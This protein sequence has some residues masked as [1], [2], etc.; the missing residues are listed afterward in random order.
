MHRSELIVLSPDDLAIDFIPRGPSPP[1]PQPIELGG[2]RGMLFAADRVVS[3]VREPN[4]PSPSEVFPSIG[5][6]VREDARSAVASWSD[7][8]DRSLRV[9]WRIRQVVR[10]LRE[11]AQTELELARA[12][13]DYVLEH[14]QH[15]RGGAPATFTLATGHGDAL[16]LFATLLRAAGLEPDI[17]YA[18]NLAADRS[19]PYLAPGE[20]GATLVRVELDDETWW[21]MVGSRHAPF[22]YLPATLRGQPGLLAGGTPEEVVLPAI[23]P[24]SDLVETHIEG[25]IN[26]DGTVT[27]DVIERFVGARATEFRTQVSRIPAAERELRGA[28]MLGHQFAGGVAE[29]VSFDGV[30]DRHAP[31][32]LHASI[33][34]RMLIRREEGAILVPTRLS[35]ATR[36]SGLARLSERRTPLIFDD[37]LHEVVE[38]VLRLPEGALVERLCES[39]EQTFG[40]ARFSITCAEREGTLTQR[41]EI[42]LP[43]RRIMP[44]DYQAF[45]DFLQAYDEAASGESRIVLP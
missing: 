13:Y 18:W 17:L 7:G 6:V 29:N 14:V 20:M 19:G 11:P 3:Q 40:E 12:C 34:S 26:A 2:L 9:D 23:S 43:P 15:G 5:S 42:Y 10:D 39:V 38:Q 36:Y 30:D 41:L 22:G 8:M 32:E 31:I 28:A 44:A 33:A 4:M 37:E 27:A 45:A 35:Q 1:T 24:V 16:L 21:L 25:A